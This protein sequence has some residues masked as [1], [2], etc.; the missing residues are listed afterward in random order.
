VTKFSLATSKTWT[1]KEGQRH[2]KT[3]WHRIVVWQK[4]AELCQQYLKKGSQIFVEGELNY[5]SWEDD[6]G[7][8]YATDIIASTIKFLDSKNSEERN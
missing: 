5:V 7:K 6:K 3:E 1:D 4:L 8:H 2:E